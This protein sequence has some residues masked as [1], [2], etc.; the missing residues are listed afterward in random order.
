MINAVTASKEHLTANGYA[1]GD[2]LLVW[3]QGENDAAYL[4]SATASAYCTEYGTTC[5]TNEQKIAYYKKGFSRIVEKLK[6]DIGLSSAFNI[7]IGHSGNKVLRNEVIIEAQNQ[8]CRENPDCIMV[9]TIFAGAKDFVEED[10]SK[11]NLMID[12]SHYLPEGYLRAGLEAGVNAGIYQKSNKMIKPIL[13]EYNTLYKEG[14]ANSPEAT[15]YERDIDKYIY[16]PCRIDL[17][18]MRQF[19]EP[20]TTTA[21]VLN[22]TSTEVAIGKTLKLSCSYTPANTSDTTLIYNSSSDAIAT[23]SSTGIVTGVS[24]GE[25]V[26]TAK[27]ASNETITSTITLNIVE[28]SNEDNDSSTGNNVIVVDFDFTTNTLNDYSLDGSFTIPDTSTPENIEYDDSLGM[29]LNNNLPYGLTLTNPV[30]ASRP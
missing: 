21:I 1:L 15:E 29:S 18:F 23:V 6:E 17:N 25:V 19:T 11:R 28:A 26:I 16:D 8:L 13:L 10:G 30:D 3:C 4:G 12:N 27:L 14:T 20:V 7:R 5:T 24:T 22:T 2:V 9:S